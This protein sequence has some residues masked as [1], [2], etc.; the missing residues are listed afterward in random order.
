[1]Y[2]SYVALL[3]A[4]SVSAFPEAWAFQGGAG[5]AQH[6]SRSPLLSS[7]RIV[8]L[9]CSASDSSTSRRGLLVGAAAA[10]LWPTSSGAVGDKT[11]SKFATQAPPTDKD[12]EP[13]TYLDSGVGFRE[14][15]TGKGGAEVE[16]G[17]RVTINCV[18]RL[19]NLNGVKFFSTKEKTD[20]FGEGTPLSFTIGAGEALPGLE[21][22]MLGMKKGS[23]RKVLVPPAMGYA[24]GDSLLPQPRTGPGQ[25]RATLNSVLKNPRRDAT[26]LFEVKVESVKSP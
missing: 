13:F 5:L 9:R 19:L 12:S 3:L 21:E 25:G 11:V 24:A 6:V 1:M 16:E 26:L 18:G 22:G 8:I 2:C 15:V 17:S 23:I 10:A 7:S 14:Y 4:L 20:E